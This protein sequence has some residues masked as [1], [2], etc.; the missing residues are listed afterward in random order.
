MHGQALDVGARLGEL[1]AAEG[2]AVEHV[3]VRPVAQRPAE[4]A[5]LHVLNLRTWRHDPMASGFDGDELDALDDALVAIAR[6]GPAE[7]VEQDLGELVVAA[8]S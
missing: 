3:A 2:L 4:M 1:A 7:P 8:P 5:A 6:G